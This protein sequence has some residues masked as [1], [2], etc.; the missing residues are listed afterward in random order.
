MNKDRERQLFNVP[1]GHLK[2]IE[3]FAIKLSDV[4]RDIKNKFNLTDREWGDIMSGQKVVL[5]VV[6]RGEEYSEKVT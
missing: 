1:E 4:E 2:Q 6:Y 5:R 3:L